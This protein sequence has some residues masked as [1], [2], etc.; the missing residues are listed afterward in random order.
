MKRRRGVTR[1]LVVKM[2]GQG[3]GMA[4]IAKQLGVSLSIVYRH[5]RAVKGAA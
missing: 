4:Q 1:A 2:V 5:A 3:A